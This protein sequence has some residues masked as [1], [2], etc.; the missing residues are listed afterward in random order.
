MAL[1]VI[2]RHIEEVKFMRHIQHDDKSIAMF[3][4]VGFYPM[5]MFFALSGFLITYQLEVEKVKSSTINVLHFYKNRALR[6]LPLFYLSIFIYWVVLPYSPISDYYNSVFFKPWFSNIEPLYDIP[7]W[8]FLILSMVLLPHLAYM[9]SLMNDRSW[10]YG[11]QHWSVGVEEIFYI[12][13]PLLWR[14]MTNF[15][16]FIIKCFAA[17]YIVLFGSAL[18]HFGLK[19]LFHI[20]WLSHATIVWVYFVIFSNAFCFF[21]GAIAIYIY[22]YRMDIMEK[23]ITGR[24][25]FIS[26]VLIIIG[27]LSSFEFPIIIKELMCTWYMICILYL[28]KTGKS[29]AIFE[30][31]FIVYLGKITYAVYLVHFAAILV[32]MYILEHFHIHEKSLWLFNVLQYGGTLLLT[33]SVSAFL[34]EFYEK[35]FLAMR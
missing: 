31:P 23:Y 12:F 33:F 5:L 34:Y 25:A 2:Y 8:I 19:K 16:H 29:Y 22:L 21:I 18:L 9:I 32:V 35:K 20:E 13:W 17:Y 6:I 15:K 11:V 3:H 27:M 7:K 14:K 24:L 1:T 4:S 30:H 26:F 10:M 28:L